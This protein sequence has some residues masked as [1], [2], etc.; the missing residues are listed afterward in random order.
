MFKYLG[1]DLN[2]LTRNTQQLL[3]ST[4]QT[5]L[6]KTGFQS[7]N[8]STSDYTSDRS[9]QSQ[10]AAAAPQPSPVRENAINKAIA[11]SVKRQLPKP[12]G[13]GFAGSGSV[14]GR[15]GDAAASS[16]FNNYYKSSSPSPEAIDSMQASPYAR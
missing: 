6:V 13:G 14:G 3:D 5:I 9:Q 16:T 8:E 12:G 1:L 15:G 10:Q 7:D 2:Y 4:V 11:A